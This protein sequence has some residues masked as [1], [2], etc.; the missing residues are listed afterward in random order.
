M[1]RDGDWNCGECNNHNFAFR[2]ECKRCGA[3][4]GSSGGGG[5]GG[6]GAY[7][8]PASYGGG[9]QGSGSFAGLAPQGGGGY[10]GGSGYG[11]PQA[12]PQAYGGA[13]G[14]VQ[15]RHSRLGRVLIVSQT[16]ASH[17]RYL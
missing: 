7:T 14:A 17:P 2:D 6:A 1:Q 13:Y 12:A 4:K 11:A 8:A 16:S 9:G 10:G 3:A 15:V 5:G